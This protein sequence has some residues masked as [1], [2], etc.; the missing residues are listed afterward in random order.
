MKKYVIT[1]VVIVGIM[2]VMFGSYYIYSNNSSP[3]NID[4]LKSKADEEITYLNST[5]ISMMNK[6]NNI[7][8]A[9][10]KV[11]E[12][13]VTSQKQDQGNSSDKN[14]GSQEGQS[15]ESNKDESQSNSS[16]ITN[17]NMNYSSILVNPD[18]NIEWDYIKKEIEKM[19]ATWTTVL[20]DLNA[21]N[22]NRDNLLKYNSTLD[23][24]T[25]ALENKDKK[26]A[27]MKL[28]DLYSLLVSYIKDYSNDS[29]TVQVLDTKSNILYAYAF[30][31]Y[32]DKW[33][34]MK[35]NIKKA[36]SAYT[37]IINSQLQNND[38]TNNINKAYILLN[39]IE[40]S[41]NKKNKN[42]FY[43]NYK[44]LMQELEIIQL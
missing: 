27:M 16:T 11:V 30:A 19:Y 15:G 6:F 8:Y 4:T 39:E 10:Y 22:V 38:N 13:K 28:A 33:S 42:I 5:I 14:V 43:I 1:I 18:K 9:N 31:E 44:N 12:E 20:I 23:D 29:K 21:L 32:D 3:E 35:D 2:L 17:I 25:Q 26:V 36:Q 7:T 37:N 34:E 40:K 41:T 24:V